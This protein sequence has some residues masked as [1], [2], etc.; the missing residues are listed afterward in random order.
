MLKILKLSLSTQRIMPLLLIL[1]HSDYTIKNID[2]EYNIFELNSLLQS[3]YFC[4]L[5]VHFGHEHRIK[6]R[7]R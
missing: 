2:V 3:P 6:G 1:K 5:V 7:E 4:L